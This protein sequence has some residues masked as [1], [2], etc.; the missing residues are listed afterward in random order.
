MSVPD[1]PEVVCLCGSVRFAAEIAAAE[2]ELTL[3]GAIVLAPALLG[4]SGT[5]L[6]TEQR[7][8][9]GELHLRRIDPG[10]A[11]QL[12]TAPDDAPAARW[13]RC[14]R[15]EDDRVHRR[16]GALPSHH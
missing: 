9:L 6:T 3:A 1:R 16:S 12:R 7:T 11:S 4:A 15:S 10:R 13:R 2:R 5:P 14:R 8:A